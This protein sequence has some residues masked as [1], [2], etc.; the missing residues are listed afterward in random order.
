MKNAFQF[1]ALICC[2]LLLVSCGST[3]QVRSTGHSL[4]SESVDRLHMAW[5]R[6]EFTLRGADSVVPAPSRMATSEQL[7]MLLE[8]M[9]G[10]ISQQ[11][12]SHVW[13]AWMD[14]KH[15][16]ARGMMYMAI[17]WRYRGNSGAEYREYDR[18]HVREFEK[19]AVLMSGDQDQIRITKSWYGGSL[20]P[21]PK[22]KL[23]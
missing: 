22:P 23:P 11:K 15:D 2:M 3:T 1:G 16:D 19:A 5:E 10:L 21:T 18:W 13:H 9:N 7:A 8:D 17:N 14:S 6:V 4:S 12:W 20:K